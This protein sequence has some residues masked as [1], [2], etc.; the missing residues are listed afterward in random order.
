[1]RY[2]ATIIEKENNVAVSDVMSNDVIHLVCGDTLQHA[3]QR[4]AEINVGS[5]PVLDGDRLAGIVTDR[6]IV[7]RAVAKGSSPDSPVDQAMT[8][9]LVTVAPDSSIDDAARLMSE[10][11]IRRLYVTDGKKLVG[12]LSLGDLAIDKTSEAGST[13]REISKG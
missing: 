6:D 13:L 9:D 5:L 4:M 10:R 3:A 1:V 11:Q 2:P 8:T 12:V 7:L